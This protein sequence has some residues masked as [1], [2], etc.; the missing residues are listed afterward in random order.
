MKRLGWSTVDKEC[1]CL[2]PGWILGE[3]AGLFEEEVRE[4][5]ERNMPVLVTEHLDRNPM[6]TSPGIKPHMFS[7]TCFE[8]VTYNIA[9]LEMEAPH[10]WQ[11]S[12]NI[13]KS[14]PPTFIIC[15]NCVHKL[16]SNSHQ[17]Q[18]LWPLGIRAPS[19][20]RPIFRFM[21]WGTQTM[22][23]GSWSEIQRSIFG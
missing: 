9:P 7:M 18:S 13:H 15:S 17:P 4:E 10:V 22:T 16:G 23:W 6:L 8:W 11:P 2:T 12:S 21:A 3:I 5:R 14:I 20:K 19:W 1:E